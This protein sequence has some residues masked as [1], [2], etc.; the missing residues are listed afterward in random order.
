MIG[1]YENPAIAEIWSDA[2]KLSLWQRT[3]LAVLQAR[4]EL[5]TIPYSVWLGIAQCLDLQTCPI[6]IEW[7]GVE[8]AR[9]HHDLN[10]FV[11]ERARHLPPNLEQHFH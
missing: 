3:E 1:R 8:D 2:H 10:A 6:D 11:H 9:I 5:G 4:V 7:W